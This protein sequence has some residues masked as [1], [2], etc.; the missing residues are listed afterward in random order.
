MSCRNILEIQEIPKMTVHHNEFLMQHMSALK[1]VGHCWFKQPI[2][3][4]SIVLH[5]GTHAI[6]EELQVVCFSSSCLQAHTGVLVLKF[7]NRL[8]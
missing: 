2:H 6:F 7:T 3:Q 5:A 1:T 8:F 4:R